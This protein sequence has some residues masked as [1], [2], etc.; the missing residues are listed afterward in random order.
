MVVFLSEFV[1]H[2]VL[3]FGFV[4]KL[5]EQSFY[6]SFRRFFLPESQDFILVKIIRCPWH[7][8]SQ[9]MIKRHLRVSLFLQK[10][11]LFQSCM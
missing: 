6:G 10:K 1:I 3:L 2:A 11:I 4:P 8:L 5:K 7:K 9:A